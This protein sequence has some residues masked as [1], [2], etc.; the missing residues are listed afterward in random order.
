M[1]FCGDLVQDPR[2]EKKEVWQQK[3]SKLRT[4]KLS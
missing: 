2:N 4:K 3:Q 1:D